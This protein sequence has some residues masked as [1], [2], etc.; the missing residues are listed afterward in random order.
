MKGVTF[1]LL[2]LK[3]FWLGCL[4]LAFG[5][6]VQAMPDC[7]DTGEAMHGCEWCLVAVDI[8]DQPADLVDE[9]V[10]TEF[11]NDVV[12]DAGILEFGVRAIGA[13]FATVPRGPPDRIVT[14]QNWFTDT[15][16]LR[17]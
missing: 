8:L 6:N 2:A 17:L 15:I 11:Q 4:T 12:F 5:Q 14:A 9:L 16:R 1:S 7:H 13:V 10:E 3:V